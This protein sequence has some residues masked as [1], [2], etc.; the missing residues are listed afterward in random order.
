MARERRAAYLA[1]ALV[2][3]AAITWSGMLVF[4][5]DAWLANAD[6]FSLAFGV[7]ARFAP[8]GA[9]GGK[10]VLHA[11]GA[12]LAAAEPVRFSFV[13]FVLLLLASVTFDGYMETPLA[14]SVD[15]AIQGSRF[16]FDL[17]E[18]GFDEAQLLGTA[19]LAAFAVGFVLIFLATS[20]LMKIGTEL[21]TK[22]VACAFV[23][24]LVPIAVAYHLAH[25]FSLLLTA[26]QFV[27][28]LASDPFGYGWDLFG[29]AR[30]RVDFG[31]VNPYVF[32]YGA[33]SLIV[34]GHVIAVLVAHAAAERVFGAAQAARRELPMM[35]LMVG[36]TTAS[37][38]ILAQPVVG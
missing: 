34:V 12:G 15:T 13:A 3:Y 22:A 21:R 11:P 37:L 17:S 28:P 16:L 32:W 38:W 36:Y 2:A 7:L 14:R 18:L 4:G 23:L 24:S 20:A 25:Y 10:L 8:L 9:E 31:V 26:G 27:I 5:R 19:Q 1:T 30:Y 35:A 29:T 33:A 6:A